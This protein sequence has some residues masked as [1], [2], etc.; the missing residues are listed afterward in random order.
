MHEQMMLYDLASFPGLPTVPVFDCLQYAKMEE[1]GPGP[2]YHMNDVL[3]T[4][5]RGDSN[6]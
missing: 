4:V 1:E 6:V 5:D 2:F 3:S